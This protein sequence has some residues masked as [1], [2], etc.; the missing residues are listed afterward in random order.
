MLHDRGQSLVQLLKLAFV[1]QIVHQRHQYVQLGAGVHHTEA[2][3]AANRRRDGALDEA[4]E[5]LHEKHD[6]VGRAELHVEQHEVRRARQV[7]DRDVLSGDYLPLGQR[8]DRAKGHP[9]RVHEHSAH[10]EQAPASSGFFDHRVA[11]VSDDVSPVFLHAHQAA[12]H[13]FFGK[14]QLAVFRHSQH[15]EYHGAHDFEPGAG[16]FLHQGHVE[17]RRDQ[18]AGEEDVGNEDHGGSFERVREQGLDALERPDAQQTEDEATQLEGVV[19]VVFVILVG[20]HLASWE[21][22]L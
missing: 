16:L 19:Y 6:L 14:Q 1:H 15:R 8:Y 17:N 12:L 2:G 13:Q 21:V 7:P 9:G 20:E 10:Q 3:E 11:F 22:D 4:R 5:E 18:F